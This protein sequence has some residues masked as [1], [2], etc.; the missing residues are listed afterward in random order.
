LNK[1]KFFKSKDKKV[2]CVLGW[3]SMGGRGYREGVKEGEYGGTMCPCMK[4]EK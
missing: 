3:I 4:M 1:Q 2:K